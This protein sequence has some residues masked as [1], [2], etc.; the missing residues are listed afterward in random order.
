MSK[1]RVFGRGRRTSYLDRTWLN[2]WTVLTLTPIH[3]PDV[4]ELHSK[5]VEFMESDPL[6]PLCCTLEAG[7][8]RWLPV[9]PE[10]RRRHVTETIVGGD[11]FHVDDAFSYLDANRPDPDSTAPFK[12]IVGPASITFYFAH[13]CGDA[14]VFSPFAV[15]MALGDVDGLRPLRADAGL[16]VALSIFLKESRRHWRDWWRHMRSADTSEP[17]PTEAN[18][19]PHPVRPSATTATGTLLS[20][21]EFNAFKA[22]RK[23]ALPD[24]PTTALMAS[25]VYRALSAEGISV[26]DSGFYTLVDLRR[27][28]PK[29][30]AL[31]PGNFAKSAFIPADMSD[32]E[33]VATALRELV[34]SSRA[35]PALLAGAVSTA[36]R[37]PTPSAPPGEGPLTMTF[38]SMMRNP[39]VEHIPW[40]DPSNAHYIT[41]AYPVDSD[42]IS[43]SACAVE[44]RV[45]FSASFDPGR[46]D[47][48]AVT[49]ALE[50]LHDMAALLEPPVPAIAGPQFDG[51]AIAWIQSPAAGNGTR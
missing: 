18:P 28:L 17:V 14:A 5:M 12:V 35:V 29:K 43:V 49:R 8:G 4:D 13:A 3:S 41:M 40:L 1:S 11:P 44:G 34:S 22:W 42:G 24:L 30:Q 32:M 33:A 2:H 50:R 39:G 9:A 16:G 10:D 47:V 6:H 45:L 19:V 7:G 20:A 27:H 26:N 46:V 15:L 48:Q 36:L 51:E 37:R 25:A 21:S 31:R 23:T 38:N